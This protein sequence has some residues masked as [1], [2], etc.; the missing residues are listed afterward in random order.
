MP[1]GGTPMTTENFTQA[2]RD[3]KFIAARFKGFLESADKLDQLGSLENAL[4]EYQN[5]LNATLQEKAKA[6]ASA[7]E[8]IEDAKKQQTEIVC[9]A[10]AHTSR[11]IE[12]AE[13]NAR[14]I[15]EGAR[16][17]THETNEALA[18]ARVELTHV[19]AKIAQAKQHHDALAEKHAALVEEHDRIKATIAGLQAKFGQALA[20]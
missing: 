19:T 18:A 7:V 20:G 17:A 16:I 3:I 13:A 14:A 6:E 12:D 5:R 1:Q 10:H 8:I 9:K 2:V 11:I 4:V 15:V